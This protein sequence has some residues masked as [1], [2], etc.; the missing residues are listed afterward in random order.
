MP[1]R[2]GK[3]LKRTSKT[4]TAG[5]KKIRP[6][7]DASSDQT[8][9]VV[10]LTDPPDHPLPSPSTSTVSETPVGI[11]TVGAPTKKPGAGRPKDSPVWSLFRYDEER[12]ELICLAD[13]CSAVLGGCNTGNANSSQ[14]QHGV[15]DAGREAEGREERQEA[16]L[17]YSSDAGANG[18]SKKTIRR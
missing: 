3:T 14:E 6:S 18:S 17:T 2:D 13:G 4:K 15:H 7:G 10:D 9:N 5:S 12:D 1:R 11:P 16:K 8:E